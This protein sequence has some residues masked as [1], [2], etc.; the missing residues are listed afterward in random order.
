[1]GRWQP[2]AR[3]RL[4][5]AALELFLEHGFEQTTVAEIAERAGL[6]E[7]TFFRYFADKRE[8]LFDGSAALT[9]V[10]VSAV[11]RAG[12]QATPFEAA[13]EGIVAAGEAL[14][15]RRDFARKRQRIL[16][17]N[18][19]LQE[20][21]LIKLASMATALA[22]AL[23]QRGAPEPAA[24]L[25]A[26]VAIAVFRSAFERWLGETEGHRLSQVIRGS[27]QQLEALTGASG[28]VSATPARQ[29][30]AETAATST[31]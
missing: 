12:E 11:A 14:Q 24:S 26:E 29:K 18:P 31:R 8:V 5:E 16:V 1:V 9:E 30:T 6:T 13:A 7:R 21:E 23:R 2:N 15:D 10:L 28:H 3:G 25:V 27:V 19:E 22:G 4:Q 20:R 17:A